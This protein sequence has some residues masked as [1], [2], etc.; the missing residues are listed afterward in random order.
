M[1]YNLLTVC[2]DSFVGM[3]YNLLTVCYDAFMGMN[4]NLLTVCYDT[5]VGM[6]YNLLTVCYDGFVAH[7]SSYSWSLLKRCSIGSDCN[8]S[9]H[10]LYPGI[11]IAHG[12]VCNDI[13]HTVLGIRQP[14][15][16]QYHNHVIG[17]DI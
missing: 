11:A 1:K 4:Y 14:I 9:L 17:G 15:I 3:N 16:V 8:D 6:N 12:L 10:V 2:Y 13:R 5:F 7:R